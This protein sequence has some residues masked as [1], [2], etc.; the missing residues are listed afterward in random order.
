MPN[1][2]MKRVVLTGFPPSD[3]VPQGLPSVAGMTR[4]AEG[5]GM[6]VFNSNPS[7]SPF[8]KGREDEGMRLTIVRNDSVIQGAIYKPV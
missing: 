3:I 1:M 2:E 7:V 5:F 6:T 4:V 8:E